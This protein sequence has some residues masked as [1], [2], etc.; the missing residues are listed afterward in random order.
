MPAAPLIHTNL[1][2]SA[3]CTIALSIIPIKVTMCYSDYASCE[4]MP[5]A[6]MM[7]TNLT[8]SA[9]CTIA[10]SITPTIGN[11]SHSD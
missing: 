3:A 1:T 7:H 10:L 4:G 2:L 9:A 5:A 8:L 6:P 11:V